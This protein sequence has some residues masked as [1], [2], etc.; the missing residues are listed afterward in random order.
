MG[1]A[2][3]GWTTNDDNEHR[4]IVLLSRWMPDDWVFQ[5]HMFYHLDVRSDW[6]VRMAGKNWRWTD[7]GEC[8]HLQKCSIQTVQSK[9]NILRWYTLSSCPRAT[10]TSTKGRYATMGGGPRRLGWPVGLQNN[11][12][13]QKN[14]SLFYLLQPSL[15]LTYIYPLP[16]IPNSSVRHD[17]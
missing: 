12:H 7:Q 14:H 11:N 2:D 10:C 4:K 5:N 8:P 9:L 15:Y 6:P 16:R 17:F 1:D 3:V 13:H